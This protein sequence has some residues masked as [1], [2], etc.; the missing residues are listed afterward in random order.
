MPHHVILALTASLFLLFGAFS[1]RFENGMFTAPMFCV[2]VGL[3]AGPLGLGLVELQ[4]DNEVLTIIGEVALAVIL[5]T[6]ASGIAL[7]RLRQTWSLPARLLGIGLPLTILLGMLAAIPFFPEIP[8]V[9][10]AVMACILAPTDAA[11]GIAIV[12][13]PLVPERV[14]DT[15]NVESGLNDG[16]ALPPIL[17]LFVLAAV[18]GG[19]PAETQGWLL[20]MLQELALG[21][22]VGAAIGQLG[23]RLLDAAWRRG[24]MEET[25]ARLV[26]PGLAILAFSSANLMNLN[27]FVAAYLAG[28][29]LG[30]QAEGFRE[31]LRAFGEADGAQF[32]LFVF[33][34]F[35]LSFLPVAVPHWDARMLVYALLSLTLVRLLPV[36]LS[37]AGAGLDGVTVAFI[38]WSGPRGIASVLYLTLVIDRF[39]LQGHETIFATIVLTVFLSIF[40]HGMSA[41]PLARAYGGY[42]QGRMPA[43]VGKKSKYAR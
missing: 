31:K 17:A 15:L 9:W 3:V 10:L 18:Q 38:G 35:G 22:L 34:L 42:I 43:R 41:A 7:S 26:S 25:F 2:L 8:L 6:D 23:G 5:F 37:L 30:V 32:A 19:R 21:A 14:R 40:L 20:A 39:G 28:L 24:W 27:G 16:I 13:S 36:A 12:Q 33:L 1:K 29:M 11:L 4:L